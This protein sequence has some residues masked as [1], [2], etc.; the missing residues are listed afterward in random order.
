MSSVLPET[1]AATPT[2]PAAVPEFITLANAACCPPPPPPDRSVLDILTRVMAE[3]DAFKAKLQANDAAVAV[4]A[5]A[6][7]RKPRQHRLSRRATLLK[8]FEAAASTL[9]K[10]AADDSDNSDSDL[11]LDL[12]LG[13]NADDG[14]DRDEAARIAKK[15]RL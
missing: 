15:C 10:L 13:T 2:A 9:H 1:A 8:L 5:R 11:D 6:A 12:D 3:R 14:K 4:A 7:P